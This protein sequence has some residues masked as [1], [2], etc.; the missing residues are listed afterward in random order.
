VAG[1]SLDPV[2]QALL[3]GGYL[4][5]RSMTISLA[6]VATTTVTG[7]ALFGFGNSTSLVAGWDNGFWGDVP[8]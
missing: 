3:T 2:S 4:P 5:I 6:G 8:A 7:T 1:R